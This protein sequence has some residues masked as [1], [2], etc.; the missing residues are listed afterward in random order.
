MACCQ[1]SEIDV[2]NFARARRTFQNSA[3]FHFLVLL[4]NIDS[5][6]KVKYGFLA[7]CPG[8]ALESLAA[9]VFAVRIGQIIFEVECIFVKGCGQLEKYCSLFLI[10]CEAL[11][12][13]HGSGSFY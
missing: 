4:P 10:G 13:V 5:G 8:V 3:C 12:F 9:V 11:Q 1:S 6:W 2:N 7:S